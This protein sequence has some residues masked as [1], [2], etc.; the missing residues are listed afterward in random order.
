MPIYY[1]L[2]C[3]MGIIGILLITIGVALWFNTN[4]NANRVLTYPLPWNQRIGLWL[5]SKGRALIGWR[6]TYDHTAFTSYTMLDGTTYTTA[7][8]RNCGKPTQTTNAV[9]GDCMEAW[10]NEREIRGY[11][12]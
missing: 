7:L 2:P 12:L 5:V 6:E 8:C 11:N 3:A 4:S 10:E 1:G 9:C